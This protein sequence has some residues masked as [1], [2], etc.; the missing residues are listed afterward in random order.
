MNGWLWDGV[1]DA[2]LGQLLG[3]R[4]KVVR[5]I[6]AGGFGAVLERLRGLIER[7]LRGLGSAMEA[8]GAPWTPGRGLPVWKK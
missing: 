4:Y 1:V 7:D 3:N 5:R 6:G 8:A 2:L